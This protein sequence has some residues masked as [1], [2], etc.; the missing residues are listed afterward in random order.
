V[1]LA[2][3]G[4]RLHVTTPPDS[5]PPSCAA[6]NVVPSGIVSVTTASLTVLG[7]AFVTV[8]VYVR[9]SPATAGSGAAP[10]AIDRSAV[11]TVVSWSVATLFAAFASAVGDDVMLACV[12]SVVPVNPAGT[13]R[14]NCQVLLAAAASGVV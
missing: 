10:A 13:S 12:S 9:S 4:P 7:P 1:S 3:S 14:V 11:A 5:V 2:S 6:L 8:I